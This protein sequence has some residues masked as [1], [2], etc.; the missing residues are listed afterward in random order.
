MQT[1]H[2]G[3]PKLQEISAGYEEQ[4]V[5]VVTIN[6]DSPHSQA[7]IRPFMQRHRL[8]LR[9]LLD[10]SGS[11]KKQ[12]QLVVVPSTF[13][14]SRFGEVVYRHSGYKPGDELALRSKLDEL[15]GAQIHTN[16]S[17]TGS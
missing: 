3:A 2:Q 12:F 9:V 4:G 5:R 17:G 10:K 13:I 14:I 16:Q 7:E 8:K 11:V 15:L 6:I 1:L